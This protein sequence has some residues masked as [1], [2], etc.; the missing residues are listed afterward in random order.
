MKFYFTIFFSM[1]EETTEKAQTE[2]AQETKEKVEEKKEEAKKL[3]PDSEVLKITSWNLAS[4]NAA[5]EHGLK[6]YIQ[7]A[8]PDI[9]CIQETKLHDQSKN[10]ISKFKLDGY[11][12]YFCHA[13]KKGYSGTAIYTKIKPKLIQASEGIT[14]QN[15]R[16]I[17]A[18]FD[19]FYLLNT[20]VINMGID[21]KN[22][23]A[24]IDV[25]NPEIEKLIQNLSKKKPVIWTG[26]LNVAHQ[27][28]DIWSTE[29][30]QN[31]AGYTDV[32]RK[33]F[34]DFIKN[35]DYVDVFR[36][37]Y[38]D[39]QQFTF[40]NYRGNAKGKNQG[41]RIDYFMMP[42]SM[43]KDGLIIDCTIESGDLSD[44]QPISLF[45]NRKMILTENDKPVEKADVESLGKKTN[46]IL[47]FFSVKPK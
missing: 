12:G 6:E 42:K 29:G 31:I 36:M 16:C 18:E 34:D 21:L 37:L 32:E 11:H 38:P 33:W 7:V 40:F 45:L 3:I 4:L 26:D 10:P 23:H 1:S 28:I 13:K 46:S 2:E 39:K 5:W 27:P 47:N 15:G 24:K 20:Y 19:T 30:H 25:F 22:Q 43:I 9:F 17:T 35:N 14:D 8:Q 41:W 44:H